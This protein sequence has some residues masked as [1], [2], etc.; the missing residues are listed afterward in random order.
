MAHL[1]CIV[2]L[3][4]NQ[5][6]DTLVCLESL[7]KISYCPTRVVVVDNGSTDDSVASIRRSYPGVEVIASSHNTGCAGGRNLGLAH[8]RSLNS[9]LV[10]FLDNDTVVDPRFLSHLIDAAET[11]PGVGILSSKILLNS[12]PSVCWTAGGVVNA[13]GTVDALHY[14][15]PSLEV[16]D[17]AFYVDWVPGCVLLA[18]REVYEA[19]GTFDDSYFIYFEDIDWCVRASRLG[20]RIM[21]VPQSIVYH[22]VSQSS[23]GD[24]SPL[25]LYYWARNRL[26]FMQKQ[27]SGFR[28]LWMTA[29]M[30]SADVA[31]GI[32]DIILLKKPGHAKARWTGTLHFLLHR[33]GS[34]SLRDT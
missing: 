26:L 17:S 16:P 34:Y 33:S 9:D 2:L 13:N 15:T 32:G 29:S 18:R 30:L 22:K 12:D 23:G 7:A 27:T 4:W 31:D 21:V 8:A 10:L 25:K 19:I 28:R 14:Y 3:N 1:V 6:D 20:F 11:N 5:C 24:Y